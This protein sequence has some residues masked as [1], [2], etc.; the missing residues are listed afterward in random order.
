MVSDSCVV[1]LD[2]GL[3]NQLFQY[4]FIKS[5]GLKYGIDYF[6]D[7]SAYTEAKGRGSFE[8]NKLNVPQ[9]RIISH[10][11]IVKHI[12]FLRLLRKLPK[13]P[14]SN[15]FIERDVNFDQAAT[16]KCY[17]L[18]YGYFQ[19]Y[20]Y[21]EDIKEALRSEFT[22]NIADVTSFANEIKSC[23]NAIALHVRRG[24]YLSNKKAAS[25]MAHLT[26]EYYTSAL[27]LLKSQL[28]DA[29]VFIFSN[30]IDW[31][32][33]VLVKKLSVIAPCTIVDT[34]S[35]AHAALIDFSLMK[36]CKHQIIAN[37]TFSW[38]SAYLNP[39]PNKLVVAPSKWYQAI[40]HNL[41]DLYPSEW[42]VV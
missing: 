25:K 31:V 15:F 23:N 10:K 38:W 29:R 42:I 3:G 28:A 2:G 37:S 11:N 4:A 27:N 14:L 20:K 9:Q 24:D 33:N 16:Q 1:K 32:T 40:K 13:M 6:A 18:Y 5:I 8:L 7:I 21:F 30:D 34:S 19:S 35:M 41:S 39:Y 22:C 17:R 36:M 26:D 12:H